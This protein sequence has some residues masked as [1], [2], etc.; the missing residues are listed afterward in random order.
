[1]STV[2]M[3]GSDTININNHVFN[4][5]ATGTCVELTYPDKIAK[6]KVGK[7]GNTIY[8]LNETGKRAEL[9]VRV[10][11]GSNDDKFMLNLLTQQ[12]ANFAGF[13]LM[14][15]EFIKKI[16]DG[17]GNIASDT[18]ILGGGIFE[19]QPKALMNVEGDENQSMTEYKLGFSN[20]PR[21]IS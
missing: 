7:N 3:T 12:Q 8:A 11:R 13:P 5:L 19:E 14:P 20:V 15:G 2:A 4:D 21:A 9:T 10:I 16:G 17:K 1:M 18:Y 6:M